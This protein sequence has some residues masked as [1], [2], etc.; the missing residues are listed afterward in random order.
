MRARYH[1]DGGVDTATALRYGA[2]TLACVDRGLPH[3]V[4]I[5]AGAL[6]GAALVMGVHQRLEDAVAAPARDRAL[7]RRTGGALVQGGDGVLYV[8]IALRSASLLLECPPDRVL[9]RNVRP[10]LSALTYGGLVAHYFGRDFVSVAS[11]PAAYVAWTRLGS[12][13]VLLEVFIG[14]TRSF[15]PQSSENGY[16]SHP[17]PAWAGKTPTCLAALGSTVSAEQTLMRVVDAYAPE[18]VFTRELLAPSDIPPPLEL[19]LE[20]S[21]GLGDGALSW[22]PPRAV[23]I[24]FV[25]A[26]ASVDE[27]GRFLQL[28]VSGDFFCD[29]VAPKALALELVG[30]DAS[31]T[32]ITHALNVAFGPSGRPLEGVRS[33]EVLREA[34]LDAAALSLETQGP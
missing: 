7:R 1:I 26:G 33:L 15:A 19:A 32:A 28:G 17:S 14:S 21:R 23:P 29:E 5:Y 6:S 27:R 34:I 2:A 31:S 13:A 4:A 11:K 24:G 8:A 20:G 3:E 12:G 22:S 9:N 25:S 18:P 30:K 16:P 10:L